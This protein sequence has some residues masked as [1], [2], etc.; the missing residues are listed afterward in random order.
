MKKTLI[1]LFLLVSIIAGTGYYQLSRLQEKLTAQL[2]QHD[3]HVGTVELNFF[4]PQIVLK[5]VTYEQWHAE[6]VAGKL[7]LSG[8]F[9]QSAFPFRQIAAR[10][11]SRQNRADSA[12]SLLWESESAVVS[13]GKLRFEG[14]NKLSLDFARPFYNQQKKIDLSFKK[15]TLTYGKDHAQLLLEQAVLNQQNLGHIEIQTTTGAQ[16][17]MLAEITPVQCVEH[18]RARLRIQSANQQSAVVFTGENY[19]AESLLAILQL[20]PLLGGKVDFD[21]QLALGD[22]SITDGTFYF[23]ARN[24]E[25][26][27]INLIALVSQ[28]LP[29]NYNEQIMQ[30]KNANTQYEQLSSLISF[31]QGG[32]DIEEIKLK[33]TALQGEGQGKIDLN[34]MQCDIRLTLSSEKYSGLALPIHFFD[35]C[36]S[37]QYQIEFN[38][39]FRRQIKNLIKG[40]WR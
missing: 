6:E 8:L 40:K 29:L 39:D 4:P 21:V 28:Y 1:G 10:Q 34:T 22:S 13:D 3:V 27:G 24:G 2:Q 36:A 20:P 5:Q 12:F 19:P 33:L 38:G 35:N 9:A 25:I 30:S 26:I 37:P 32:L 18:C 14:E 31:H 15:G 7:N 16:R 17:E 23:N 11:I